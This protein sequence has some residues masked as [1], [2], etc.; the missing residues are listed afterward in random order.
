MGPN[1]Y[2]FYYLPRKTVRDLLH[3]LRRAGQGGALL[4]KRRGRDGDRRVQPLDPDGR[5][6]DR[7]PGQQVRPRRGRPADFFRAGRRHAGDR[8]ARRGSQGRP[9]V[10]RGRQARLAQKAGDRAQGR[11]HRARRARRALAYRG[12]GRQRSHLRGRAAPIGRGAR[13]RAQR[14]ARVRALPADHGRAQGRERAHHHRRRRLGRAAL[15]CLR[16]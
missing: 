10:R 16:R 5:L 6:G 12:A 8:D 1:I 7:R 4:A 2:G 3:A 14:H 9:L 11:A 13:P 15:R